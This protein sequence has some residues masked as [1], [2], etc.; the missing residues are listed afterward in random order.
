MFVFN[1]EPSIVLKF[2]DGFWAVEFIFF[3]KMNSH[4]LR[5]VKYPTTK[6]ANVKNT[7]IR[8]SI[9]PSFLINRIFKKIPIA[10]DNGMINKMGRTWNKRSLNIKVAIKINKGPLRVKK[11]NIFHF[12][13][14]LDRKYPPDA[15]IIP[16]IQN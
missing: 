7:I 8:K 10:V 13:L 14:L 2:K 6:K 1:S 4:Q 12:D 11:T 16:P 15:K 9:L 5:V 3:A